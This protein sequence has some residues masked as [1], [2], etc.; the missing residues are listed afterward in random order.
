MEYYMQNNNKIGKKQKH[1]MNTIA[2]TN[3]LDSKDSNETMTVK[4]ITR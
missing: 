2:F 4:Q 1:S 3:D